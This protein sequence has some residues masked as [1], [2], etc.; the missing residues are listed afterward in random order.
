MINLYTKIVHTYQAIFKKR[1]FFIERGPLERNRPPLHEEPT[2]N[3]SCEGPLEKNEF[4]NTASLPIGNNTKTIVFY[5]FKYSLDTVL[6]YLF[7][8]NVLAYIVYNFFS[9]LESYPYHLSSS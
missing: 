8:I 5:Y 3:I 1:C 6:A 4:E 7:V 2:K 9:F